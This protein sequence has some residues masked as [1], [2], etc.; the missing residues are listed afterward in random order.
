MPTVSKTRRREV[1]TAQSFIQWGGFYP[2]DYSTSMDDGVAP[3]DV[4]EFGGPGLGDFS[5]EF[6]P[7]VTRAEK[8]R[9]RVKEASGAMAAALHTQR[10][11]L[12]ESGQENHGM[13]KVGEDWRIKELVDPNTLEQRT[14]DAIPPASM[15]AAELDADS[16]D[17][18]AALLHPTTAE[19]DPV[20]SA[21]FPSQASEEAPSTSQPKTV[22]TVRPTPTQ[23]ATPKLKSKTKTKAKK[24][25]H[26]SVGNTEV[27]SV[28]ATPTPESSK[29]PDQNQKSPSG[30]EDVR[31]KLWSFVRQVW[32]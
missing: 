12:R 5:P 21:S 2:Y 28:R 24:R 7:E 32:R 27:G 26:K 13:V 20:S 18:L 11:F 14:E 25:T 6:D 10:S 22:K 19:N 23:S 9:W 30:Q 29:Q 31:E 8:Q 15:T 4:H 1:R 16:E 17:A 3:K